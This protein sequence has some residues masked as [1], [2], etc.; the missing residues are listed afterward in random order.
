MY[1]IETRP[2][3]MPRMIDVLPYTLV[4][5]Y[6]GGGDSLLAWAAAAASA[7]RDAMFST[8]TEILGD[9]LGG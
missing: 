4:P 3:Q 8:S 1:E 6:T 7:G 9:I 5:T 2:K